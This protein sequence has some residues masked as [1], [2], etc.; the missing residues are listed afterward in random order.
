MD[1]ASSVTSSWSTYDVLS[2]EQIQEYQQAGI[3]YLHAQLL[4]NRGIKVPAAMR[5]FLAAD[6]DQIPDPL[7][8]IDMDKALERVSRAL[9]AREHITVYGDFDADGVTSAAL[10]TRALRALKH[11]DATLDYFI[12][13]RL[14]DIRGLSKEGIDRIKERG[15][16]LIITTDCGSSDVAEVAYARTTGIDIIITDHHQPPEPL[17]QACAMI[18]PWRPD[19]VYPERYLCGVGIAFKLAQALFRAYGREQEVHALLDLVAIGTI[20]DVG[21]LLG[22]NHTLVRL[23]LQQLNAT[24]NAGLQAL[25]NITHLQ[26]GRLRE[27]DISYV[28]GPRINAAGRMKDASIAF[29]LL[30]T[31]DADAAFAYAKEL[32]ELNLLRQQQTEELMKLVREQAQSQAS[33]QVVLVYG[34]KDT[35]PEGIIGLVAGRLSEEIQRPVFVLS[36]DSESS[37]GSARSADGFN[38]ILALRQR[39]DLFERFGGHA[40]AAGFTIANANIAELHAHLLA[41]HEENS[42]EPQLLAPDVPGTAV[43]ARF[44]A[45]DAPG[46]GMAAPEVTE[47]SAIAGVMV[48]QELAAPASTRKIDLLISR[49]E[50]LNYDAYTKVSLLAP[51][52]AGNPE[53]VFKMERLRLYRRWQSGVDGRHLRVRLRTTTNGNNT[54][55]NGTYIRG[56]S[57]I[58]SLPE[59]SL[60][61]VI[62]NLEPAWNSL[63]SDN[64]QDIWLKVLQLELVEEG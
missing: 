41:W 8:F 6:Y 34:D 33:Q 29:N 47:A 51:Y 3:E 28:L 48:E 24:K 58:E 46:V 53:P 36:Q 31:E 27:R 12:P 59:G 52:G 26:P 49:P 40:Q 11:P 61:N 56:G 63:D 43:G 54:Q 44:I 35:W 16:T 45:P 60:V 55:F 13:S 22:E 38:I 2:K 50:R 7:A 64:R 57:Q 23:G 39:A 62:F 20:G 15:T 19:C 21:Q 17:P 25:I 42:V 10:L 9:A 37:R 14:R 4:Y 1:R 30:T 32:E 5:D 18:N